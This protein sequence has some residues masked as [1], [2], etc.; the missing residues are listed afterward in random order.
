MSRYEND[1][2][3]ALDRI[4]EIE[5]AG[6]REKVVRTEAKKMNRKYNVPVHVLVKEFRACFKG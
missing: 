4:F 6:G 1:Y 2:T 3:K 5:D